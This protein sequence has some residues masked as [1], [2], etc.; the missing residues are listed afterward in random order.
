METIVALWLDTA[1]S[2]LIPTLSPPTLLNQV[3]C[4][5]PRLLS[6]LLAG[7]VCTVLTHTA[8]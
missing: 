6:S 8:S 4:T 7:S 2:Y 3:L 5:L 1:K